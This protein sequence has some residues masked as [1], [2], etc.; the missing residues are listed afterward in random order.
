LAASKSNQLV[1]AAPYPTAGFNVLIFDFR[2]HGESGGQL[3]TF[4]DRERRD[5]LGAVRWLRANHADAARQI[6]GVGASQGAAALIAAAADDSDE[7]RAIEALAVYGTYDSLPSLTRS[8]SQK[9]FFPPLRQ[10]LIHV[11]LPVASAQTGSNLTAFAPAQLVADVWPRPILIIHG[12]RDE[13]ISFDHGESL[14][15]HAYQPKYSL[16]LDGDHNEIVGSEAAGRVVVE[17]FKVA[18]PVPVI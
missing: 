4:G 8:V 18:E 1:M 5:V 3:A 12:R 10:L 17:F 7:G 13:I 16:W 14:Y 9:Y 2:A 6:F 11:G 15:E